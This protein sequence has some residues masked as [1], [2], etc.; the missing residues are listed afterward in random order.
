[1]GIKLNV[2]KTADG[3][4]CP[5]TYWKRRGSEGPKQAGK[6][7]N[8]T[9]LHV[10]AAELIEKKRQKKKLSRSCPDTRTDQEIQSRFARAVRRIEG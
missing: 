7:E 6:N 8:G 10:H 1:M 5:A 2:T 9:E 3:G 4:G